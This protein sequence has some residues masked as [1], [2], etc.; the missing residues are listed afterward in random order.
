MVYRLPPL[1]ALRAFEAA[2]RHSSFKQ[3]AEELYVTPGAISQQ[4]KVLED[5]L[6]KPLFERL[7]RTVR[8]LPAGEAML[9][10][11]REG[12]ECLAAAVEATRT[13]SERET[14]NVNAPP[15]F[16]S[17]WL[18]PRL[19]RFTELY[20]D[21]DLRLSS[22]TENIDQPDTLATHNV[23]PRTDVSDVSIRYGNGDYPGH[24]VSQIFNPVLVAACSPQLLAGEHPL[25]KPEDL[26][27]HVLIHD[28]TVP[29]QS[30]HPT[31]ADWMRAAGVEGI[32]TRKGP[33][34][35]N[36][37]ALEAAMDGL[38]VVLVLKPLIADA[39]QKGRLVIPFET[40]VPSRHAYFLVVAEAVAER[41]AVTCFSNW[42]L[43]EAASEINV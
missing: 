23:D 31:W 11:L 7:P 28:D 15:T 24:R 37:L 3:A 4:I 40:T 10:K 9:P 5:Y 25:R 29:E 1:A 34:F 39:V 14:L 42:L 16:A 41:P 35:G 17:R 21:I 13:A 19:S 26:Q 32:E 20:P 18:M 33:R 27:W 43:G 36:T 38:G 30:D 8:L 22:S 2:A 6:G 12:F